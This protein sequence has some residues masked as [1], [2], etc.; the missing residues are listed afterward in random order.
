MHATTVESLALTAAMHEFPVT[1]GTWAETIIYG[2]AEGV[3]GGS[4]PSLVIPSHERR[5]LPDRRRLDLR[6]PAGN[7]GPRRGFRQPDRDGP[8]MTR[9]DHAAGWARA[10]AERSAAAHA[11]E[12]RR[13]E[14][15]GWARLAARNLESGATPSALVDGRRLEVLRAQSHPIVGR[16][17]LIR[18]GAAVRWVLEDLVSDVRGTPLESTVDPEVARRIAEDLAR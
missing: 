11:R 8:P 9:R 3:T 1:V 2:T 12:A 14:A 4:T 10:R 6:P 16:R 7:R 15:E 18:D 17:F 5:G 13:L